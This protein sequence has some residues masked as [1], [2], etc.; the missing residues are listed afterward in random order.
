MRTVLKN[1]FMYRYFS[2]FLMFCILVRT[3][4]AEMP[5]IL[6]ISPL[7]YPFAFKSIT[8]FKIN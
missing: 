2:L 8:V 6:P 1:E 5:N 4:D 3:A 7:E